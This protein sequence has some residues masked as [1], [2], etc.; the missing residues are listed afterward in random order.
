[1]NK[2]SKVIFQSIK[3]INGNLVS[4][5]EEKRNV[6]FNHYKKFASDPSGVSFS[7]EYWENRHSAE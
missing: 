6:W 4:S 7:L 1:M 5:S 3:D 2:F